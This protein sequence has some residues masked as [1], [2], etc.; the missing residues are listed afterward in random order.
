MKISISVALSKPSDFPSDLKSVVDK[1]DIDTGSRPFTYMISFTP[2]NGGGGE[3][4]EVGIINPILQTAL[5]V[6]RWETC[7]DGTVAIWNIEWD[8]QGWNISSAT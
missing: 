7:P 3:S 8:F 2:P 6:Y 1:D 5:E 4:C